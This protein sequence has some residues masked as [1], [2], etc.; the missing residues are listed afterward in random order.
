MVTGTRIPTLPENTASPVTVIQADQIST[1]Q[2]RLVADVLRDVTG[3]DVARSGQP[4]GN[5]SMFLRG[6]DNSDTLVLMDGIRVNNGFNNAY[7]FSQLAVDNVER[8]EILRGPQSTLYGSEA[9]GG[10]INIVTKQAAGPPA[11]SVQTEYGSFR[12][13]LTRGS[14]AMRE[15][16]AVHVRRRQLRVQRR[17]SH[18]QRLRIHQLSASAHYDFS[19]QFHATSSRLT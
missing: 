8:I 2:Q 5:T 15:G 4:G 1:T 10:V 9:S 6:A 16:K 14:F 19:D 18:Q 12:V 11:G 13:V 7:D 3:L 17:R